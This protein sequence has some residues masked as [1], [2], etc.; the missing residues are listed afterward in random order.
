M[1][2]LEQIAYNAAVRALDEQ[3]ASLDELRARTGPLMTAASVAASFLGAEAIA[4]H[5]LTVWVVL[6][7]AAFTG[8]LLVSLAVLLP[9]DGLVFALDAAVLYEGLYGEPVDEAHRRLAYWLQDY[10]SLNQDT[11]DDLTRWFRVSV[12]ALVVEIVLLGL[13]FGLH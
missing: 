3:R 6:A 12:G 1:T 10:R 2:S 5:G 8:A 7:L 9:R 13:S 4:Q 11:I